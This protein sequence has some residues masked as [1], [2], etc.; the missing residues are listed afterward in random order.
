M[1][2]KKLSHQSPVIDVVLEKHPDPD[3][4]SLS[5][6]K[7]DE[8]CLVVATKSWEGV[9]KA[10]HILPDSLVDVSREEFKFLDDNKENKIKRVGCRKLRGVMS[11]GFLVPLPDDAVVGEDYSDILGVGHYDPEAELEGDPSAKQNVKPPVHFPKYDLDLYKKYYRYFQDGEEVIAL[12]KVNGANARFIFKNDEIFC[13][14]RS[15]WKGDYP[16]C[17]WWQALRATPSLE[18]L[19]RDNPNILIFGEVVGKVGGYRYGCNPG[20]VKFLAFDINV[21]GKWLDY[22]EAKELSKD[23]PWCPEVFRGAYNF[24]KLVELAEGNSL[25]DPSHIMEGVVVFPVKERQ[26]PK[27]NRLKMKIISRKYDPSKTNER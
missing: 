24:N 17:M 21:K 14:S 16:G 8:Y 15:F 26:T 19:I 3:T 7:V 6:V 23:L 20:E 2:E 1:T 9:K 18:K 12:E 13:G 10:A 5:I 25:V 22:D 11:Y 27:F 4:T